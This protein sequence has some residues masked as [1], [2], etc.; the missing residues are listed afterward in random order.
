MR[1]TSSEKLKSDGMRGLMTQA[2]MFISVPAPDYP[3]NG[4]TKKQPVKSIGQSDDLSQALFPLVYNPVQ[5]ISHGRSGTCEHSF[6]E[7]LPSPRPPALPHNPIWCQSIAGP[8][9]HVSDREH[10]IAP[11]SISKSFGLN[12]PPADWPLNVDSKFHQWPR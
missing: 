5:S 8:A 6:T 9:K 3:S 12:L 1:K 2:R 11:C 4:G 10:L 7:K